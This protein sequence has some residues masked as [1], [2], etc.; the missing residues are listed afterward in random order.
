MGA[1]FSKGGN[2]FYE[3]WS[4]DHSCSVRNF[5][6]SGRQ[7]HLFARLGYA[8]NYLGAGIRAFSQGKVSNS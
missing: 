8:G 2:R 5:V 7:L 6:S 1:V 3:K 4:I